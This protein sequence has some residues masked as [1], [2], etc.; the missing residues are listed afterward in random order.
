MRAVC[1]HFLEKYEADVFLQPALDA[2]RCS[3]REQPTSS[4]WWKKEDELVEAVHAS[5]NSDD[6]SSR[7]FAENAMRVKMSEYL[8]LLAHIEALDLLAGVSQASACLDRASELSK[9]LA[10]ALV[11]SSGYSSGVEP[12]LRTGALA[13]A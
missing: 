6:P 13:A 11:E 1:N 4:L 12:P 8:C 10:E 3:R 7:H 2:L 9:L 5:I